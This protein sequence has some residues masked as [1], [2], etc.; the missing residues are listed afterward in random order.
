MKE[1]EKCIICEN[2]DE[3]LEAI[4]QHPKAVMHLSK[5]QIRI[6]GREIAK[7]HREYVMNGFNSH[8]D[9]FRMNKDGSISLKK[10]RSYE[11]LDV[12]KQ[13]ES[14]IVSQT[15]KELNP[16]VKSKVN[17]CVSEWLNNGGIRVMITNSLRDAM[18]NCGNKL[19]ES[20]LQLEQSK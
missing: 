3:L 11:V 8:N 16:V 9:M 20:A 1:Q 12:V 2:A 15:I 5:R 6:L 7:A 19:I 4:N 17:E 13:M 10:A 18:T 14:I